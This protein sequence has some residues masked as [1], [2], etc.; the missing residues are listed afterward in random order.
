MVFY[1]QRDSAGAGSRTAKTV[2]G[3]PAHADPEAAAF[4]R[5]LRG[6]QLFLGR[7][8][9]VPLRVK[10]SVNVGHRFF[11]RR[12]FGAGGVAISM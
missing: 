9:I 6:L 2:P 7:Q 8:M 5:R 11:A 4:H 1:S 10:L 3:A 12:Q